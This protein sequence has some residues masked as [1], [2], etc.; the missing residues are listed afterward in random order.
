MLQV[1]KEDFGNRADSE[2][3]DN[4]VQLLILQEKK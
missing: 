1:W 3:I 4:L 2:V